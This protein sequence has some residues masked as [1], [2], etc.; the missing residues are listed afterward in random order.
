MEASYGIH[1]HSYPLLSRLGDVFIAQAEFLAELSAEW[2]I[3][4]L[5]AEVQLSRTLSRASVISTWQKKA[6]KN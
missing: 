5:A 1:G 2:H 3:R 6:N 4:A